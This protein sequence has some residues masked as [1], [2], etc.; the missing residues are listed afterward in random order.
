MGLFIIS[1]ESKTNPAFHVWLEKHRMITFFFTFL[2]GVDLD[3]I[4]VLSSKLEESLKAPLSE[5]AN[6]QIDDIEH[7]GF[8]LKDLPQLAVLV[9]V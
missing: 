5:K 8:F 9:S 1:R 7:V 2:S 4:T 3:A 6:K